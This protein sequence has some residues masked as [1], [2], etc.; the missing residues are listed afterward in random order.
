M[1]ARV[2]S[3]RRT[4]VG[5][6]TRASP[7]V[8]YVYRGVKVW[9]KVWGGGVLTVCCC[10]HSA[11]THTSATHISAHTHR[12]TAHALSHHT[13][14]FT[15]IMRTR[16]QGS[17]RKCTVRCPVPKIQSVLSVAVQRGGNSSA[18]CNTCFARGASAPLARKIACAC[19]PRVGCSLP[20]RAR[21]DA[22][23][24]RRPNCYRTR[25]R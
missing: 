23:L 4:R 14:A 21:V 15:H 7:C 1:R 3:N 18:E 13:R 6:N 19:C 24:G 8:V 25:C 2:S 16:M 9:V 20:H 11:A 17:V 12:L 22:R 5:S 10:L